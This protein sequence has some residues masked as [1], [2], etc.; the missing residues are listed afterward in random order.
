MNTTLRLV[1]DALAA[2]ASIA[3]NPAMGLASSGQKIAQLVSFVAKIGSEGEEAHQEL[4]DFTAKITALEE[5]NA[6]IPAEVWD[7]WE[8]RLD[9][10]HERLQE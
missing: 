1:L 6:P 7:G 9:A 4:I 8:K 5:A 2:I 10:A 3:V